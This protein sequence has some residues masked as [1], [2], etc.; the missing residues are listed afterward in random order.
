MLLLT[1]DDAAVCARYL[2]CS[3]GQSA[4]ARRQLQRQMQTQFRCRREVEWDDGGTEESLG[5]QCRNGVVV[6]VFLSMLGRHRGHDA[7]SR[8]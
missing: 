6:V 1:A 3:W 4:A 7:S 5:R 2:S 8:T